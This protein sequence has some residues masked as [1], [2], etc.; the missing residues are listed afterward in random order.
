MRNKV[1]PFPPA[2]LDRL[3]EAKLILRHRRAKTDDTCW[4][5]AAKT[6]RYTRP[7]MQ[8]PE[9]IMSAVVTHKHPISI[10]RYLA[11][12]ERS[13]IRHEYVDGQVYAMTGASRRHGSIVNAMAFALTPIARQKHCQLFTS[14]MKVRLEIGGTT[15]FYYPDLLVTCDPADRETHFC[16]APCLIAEVLSESTARIDR[17]EKLL[18]YQTLPSLETYLLVEQTDRQVELYRRANAWRV[19]S[20]SQGELSLRCLD[21]ALPVDAIYMDVPELRG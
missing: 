15:T 8:A 3:D 1:R 4:R 18:A 14:D 7:C 10:A 11:E 6:L 20:V 12:E 17:R 2:G 19:E 5:C 13:N 9:W 21:A 16:L